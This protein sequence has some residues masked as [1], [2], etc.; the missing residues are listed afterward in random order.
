[1]PPRYTIHR[2]D[3]NEDAIVSAVKRCGCW[4]RKGP[5]LD[6]WVW[7]GKWQMWM[8]VEIKVPER[9]GH[10]SEYTEAQ[11]KFFAEC[12]AHAARYWVWRTVDD[13]IRDL[14]GRR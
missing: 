4:W 6:G 1:M 7:I 8:P 14:G 10:K 2:K 11:K 5:P 13:V 9:E 12:D 3:A